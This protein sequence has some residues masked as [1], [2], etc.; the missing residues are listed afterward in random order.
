MNETIAVYTALFGD[1]DKLSDPPMQYIQCEFICFTDQQIES[2][3]WRIVQILPDISPSM[4]NRKYKILAH[5]YLKEYSISIYVDSNIKITGNP[6]DLVSIYLDK[7]DFCLPKHYLRSCVYKEAEACMNEGK[8]SAST[9]QKQMSYYRSQ[10]LPEDYG[11]TENNILLRRHNE[12][13]VISLMNSWW[14]E[15]NIWTQRDQ[16]SLSYV[17]WKVN[18]PFGF[19]HESSRNKNNYFLYSLHHRKENGL[20]KIKDTSCGRMKRNVLYYLICKYFPYY[21]ITHSIRRMLNRIQHRS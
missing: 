5:R 14:R 18:Y 17:V 8:S 12:P 6:Y 20:K 11:L 19:M 7:Y 2:K 10:G 15:L 13:K 16:L 1:Y 21:E 3:Y 4:M 9:T